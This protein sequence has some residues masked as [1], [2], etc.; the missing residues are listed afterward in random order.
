M[1]TKGLDWALCRSFLAVLRTGSLSGAARQLGVAHPTVSRHIVELEGALGSAL[2]T[3]S[4]SG[5]IP[6]DLGQLLRDPALAME[7][8]EAQMVRL[9]SGPRGDMAGTVRITASE[10]MGAEVLPQILGP[11]MVAHRTLMVELD[12]TDRVADLLRSDADIAVRM[13]RPTQGDLIPQ[14]AGQ[15]TVGLFAEQGWLAR[16]PA[17]AGL[18]EMIAS[19]AGIGYDRDPSVLQALGALGVQARPS[20]FR[21]RSDST[22]AQLAALRAGLGVGLCQVPLAARTP[23]LVRLLPDFAYPLDIWVVTHPDLRS[24][25]RIAAVCDHL[26]AGLR[27]Y[28]DPTG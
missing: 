11:L 8:A 25:A 23:G 20:D 4:P 22:L 9:A 26:L 19:G 27:A 1:L 5:L 10:I 17:P 12:L 15:V 24:V 18:T 16:N 3:R 2:F 6:T 14:R 13:V 7:A 21:L 28:A